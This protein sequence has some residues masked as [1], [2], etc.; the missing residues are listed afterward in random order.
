MQLVNVANGHTLWSEK[1]DQTFTDIFGVQDAISDSVANSLALNLSSDERKHL[2]KHYTTN[3]E[4]YD[5]YLVGL[6]FWN[7]RSKEGLEKA[8]DYFGRAVE[9]DPTFALAYALMSDCYFLQLYYDYD[10]RSDRIR[11]ARSAAE[12]ALLL[13]DSIAEA[14]VALAMVQFREKMGRGAEFDDQEAMDSLRR[15]IT[16]NPNLAIAHQRYAWA[17]S[18]FGHLDESVREMT[19]AQELDPLSADGL[20]ARGHAGDV[21][22]WTAE[23]RDESLSDR[24][25]REHRVH[26]L[27][28]QRPIDQLVARAIDGCHTALA[29][30]LLDD[31]PPRKQRADPRI[32]HR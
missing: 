9:K 3:T 23:R 27:H 2:T 21:P 15:A 24:I 16:L 29:D 20:R 6:Y 32:G 17:L 19:R 26:D 5:E 14:H 30:D 7:T 12:H 11:N 28:G 22:A 25:G 31:V 10:S 18:S 13:D 4:S 8:I 1:F